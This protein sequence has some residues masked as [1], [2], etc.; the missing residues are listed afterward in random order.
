MRGIQSPWC[1]QTLAFLLSLPRR[2]P[3]SCN[4]S[5]RNGYWKLRTAC[6]LLWFTLGTRIMPEQTQD[7][8]GC[9]GGLK[10]PSRAPSGLACRSSW[11]MDQQTLTMSESIFYSLTGCL[12]PCAKWL[13]VLSFLS[14]HLNLLLQLPHILSSPRPNS[15]SVPP[16]FL[17]NHGTNM[18]FPAISLFALLMYYILPSAHFHCKLFGTGSVF[19]QREP[20]LTW[21]LGTAVIPRDCRLIE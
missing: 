19:V 2:S 5:Y 15:F 11:S 20:L 18:T 10:P 8:K 1:T 14:P 3:G 16:S 9:K 6:R 17:N 21:S 4:P 13:F 7:Q 12:L